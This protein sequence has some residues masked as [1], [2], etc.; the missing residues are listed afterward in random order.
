MVKV[1][2]LPSGERGFVRRDSKSKSKSKERRRQRKQQEQ[3]AHAHAQAGGRE[4]APGLLS[5]A[6]AKG[7]KRCARNGLSFTFLFLWGYKPHICKTGSG[8]T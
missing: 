7:E 6:G 8:Q 2:T 1:R 4:H 3:Q 5:E